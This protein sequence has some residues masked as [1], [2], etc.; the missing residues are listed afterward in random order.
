VQVNGERVEERILGA[1]KVFPEFVV[2]EKEGVQ[3]T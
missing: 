2:E 1:L 3:D